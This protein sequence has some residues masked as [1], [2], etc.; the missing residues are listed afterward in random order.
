M[1]ETPNRLRTPPPRLGEHNEEIYLDLLGYTAEEYQAL[2]DQGLV[3]TTYP[4][5]LLRSV[6]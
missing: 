1:E 6:S 2:I 3:G 5:S 4:E